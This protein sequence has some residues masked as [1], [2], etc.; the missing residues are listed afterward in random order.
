M[1]TN[2]LRGE[3]QRALENVNKQYDGNIRFQRF[4]GGVKWTNFTL[5]V[6]DSRGPGAGS[7]WGGRRSISACWHAHRDFMKELYKLNDGA[8]IISVCARYDGREDFEA[9][10]EA[11][12]SQNVGSRMQPAFRESCCVC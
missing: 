2:A 6:N 10:F 7:S 12:G 4:D 8:T 1:R 9:K 3:L 11:T 5:R